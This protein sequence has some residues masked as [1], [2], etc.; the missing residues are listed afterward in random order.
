VRPLLALFVLGWC[1][2]LCLTELARAAAVGPI[3]ELS[4]IYAIRSDGGASID[5]HL[6][7]LPQLTRDQ[8]FVRYNVYRLLDRKQVPFESGKPVEYA[9]ANG[10]TLRVELAGV[11]TD[12]G[13]RRYQVQAQIAEPGKKAFLRSLAVTASE[14]EAFF[15]G[16][17]S[18]QGGT[19]FIELQ[20]RR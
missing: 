19:L 11:S 4:T 12:A 13:E 1:A 16:G 20:I 2:G 15:V 7:D 8:P 5:A 9:L 14:N 18:Y 10:R 3:L 17:Q 6:R